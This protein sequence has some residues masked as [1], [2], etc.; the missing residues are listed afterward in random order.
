MV[1]R[2]QPGRNAAERARSARRDPCP[3]GVASRFPA[4][5]SAPL[6]VEVPRLV[7]HDL[8]VVRLLVGPAPSGTRLAH[9]Q[10]GRAPAEI[11]FKFG[12]LIA[13]PLHGVSRAKGTTVFVDPDTWQPYPDQFAR[14]SR[15]ER[16]SPAEVKALVD[17]LGPVKAGPSATAQELGPRPRR[18]ALGKAPAV[19][20]ARLSVILAIPTAG[21]PPQLLAALKHAASF[22][23]PEFSSRT[24]ASP[25]GTRR[26]SSAASMP[27][28]RSGSRCRA[29]WP[30][31][32]PSSSPPPGGTARPCH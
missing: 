7:R 24:S 16:L 23:N 12:S 21:L 15:T 6:D 28:T 11:A 1:G 22:H 8:K 13:L 25:P 14:L 29:A 18:M 26:A 20:P 10:V 5:R 31:R 9:T 4:P 2:R 32:P 19:V 3:V 30:T 27:P 17:K